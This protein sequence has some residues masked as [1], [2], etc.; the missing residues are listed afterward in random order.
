MAFLVALLGGFMTSFTPCVYPVIPITVS[1]IGGASGGS[2]SRAFSLSL[3]YVSGICLVYTTLGI[4]AALTGQLFGQLSTS[5]WSFLVVGNVCILLSLSMF[6]VYEMPVIALGSG[7]SRITGLFTALS[8]GMVSGLIIAP[9]A[10]PVLATILVYIG[11]RQEVVFGGGLMFSYALGMG[12]PLIILGISSGLLGSLP[13]AGDWMEKIK[14]AFGVLMLAS[15]EYF[16]LKAG[17]ILM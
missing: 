15:G 1:F 11:S 2:R 10:S 3:V 14:I 4:A 5:P 7:N 13:K 12:I 17:I 8:V 16:L 6:G 9:C